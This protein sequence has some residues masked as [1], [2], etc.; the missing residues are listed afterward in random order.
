MT[1]TNLGWHQLNHIQHW[2]ENNSTNQ[3]T[4][5]SDDR[6]TPCFVYQPIFLELSQTSVA[7]KNNS[8]ELLWQYVEQSLTPHP[9][10]YRSFRRQ[11]VNMTDALPVVQPTASKL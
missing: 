9:T 4:Y 11:Y 1:E 6:Q 5:Q 2:T 8:G 10:Q 3:T 7:P